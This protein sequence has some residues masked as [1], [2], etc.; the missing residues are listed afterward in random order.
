MTKKTKVMTAADAWEARKSYNR[1][2][3]TVEEPKVVISSTN[4]PVD[5]STA[6][7]PLLDTQTAPN[8]PEPSNEDKDLVASLTKARNDNLTYINQLKEE[9]ATLKAGESTK[10]PKTEAEI[11]EFAK[12]H[13]DLYAIMVSVVK[14]DVIKTDHE[15]KQ[16][17]KEVQNEIKNIDAQKAFLEVLKA[18]PD[19]NEIK[20][21]PKFKEWVKGQ[22]NGIKNLLDS[23]SIKDA[24]LVLNLYKQDMGYGK[25]KDKKNSAKSPSGSSSGTPGGT[26]KPSFRE[27]EV[28]RM[29]DKQFANLEKEIDLARKEGRF[30]YDVSKKYYPS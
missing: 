13:P 16:S 14:R 6:S 11:E 8:P 22:T 23:D 19:A 20:V 17:L 12:K 4:P 29:S 28:S 10:L 25:D 9:I 24:I 15:L 7:A 30:I 1:S 18:H 5:T 27:S 2:V 26:E 21:D 3:G